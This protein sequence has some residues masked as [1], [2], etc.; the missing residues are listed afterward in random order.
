MLRAIE[1]QATTSSAAE[2]GFDGRLTLLVQREVAWSDDRRVARLLKA[3][4]LQV[5][6]A[7]IE[8]FNWR[9]TVAW[10]EAWSRRWPEAI[11]C[12]MRAMC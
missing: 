9:A 5:A 11:G 8:E 7:C 12:A 10:A 3:A 1:E 2:R 6:D 4:K